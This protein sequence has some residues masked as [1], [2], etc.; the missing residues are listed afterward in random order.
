MASLLL[1]STNTF[2]A[3]RIAEDYY[4]CSHYFWCSPLFDGRLEPRF[5]RP[6]PP[7]ASPAEIYETLLKEVNRGEG[8]SNRIKQ[9]KSGI[10]AGAT[11][12][13]D[14]KTITEEQYK[15][16]AAI[17]GASILIDFRPLLMVAPHD[18]LDAYL[19]PVSVLS[20]AHP[21]SPEYIAKGVP[22]AA[23]D[24]LELPSGR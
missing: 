15:E 18:R 21:L 17:V 7:T 10:M 12:H 19:T 1:Y 24:V 6:Q 3:Y 9:N 8:H 16:I 23:F 20:R 11:A 5:G 14:K 4:G 2:L 22:R 13:R